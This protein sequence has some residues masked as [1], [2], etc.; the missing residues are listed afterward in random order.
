M[1]LDRFEGFL[2][3]LGSA[4]CI[5][6][7]KLASRAFGTPFLFLEQLLG[8]GEFLACFV[9]HAIY[10]ALGAFRGFPPPS[11]CWHPPGHCGRSCGGWGNDPSCSKTW[12]RSRFS[13]A[14]ILRRFEADGLSYRFR[15]PAIRANS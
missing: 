10:R 15:R 14:F 6:A 3:N 9:Q 5:L 8:Y 11:S 7:R 13:M 2:D 1:I 4:F 12:A